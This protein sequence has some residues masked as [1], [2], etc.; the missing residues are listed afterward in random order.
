V[1]AQLVSR[2]TAR[3][4]EKLPGEGSTV[5]S[6]LGVWPLLAILSEVANE[7]ARTELAEVSGPARTSRSSRT[8]I[9]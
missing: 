3:W 9:T 5:V 1:D 2:L 4:V 6:G 7:P 8:S